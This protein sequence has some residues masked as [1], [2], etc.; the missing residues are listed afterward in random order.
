MG[1]YVC[2]TQFERLIINPELTTFRCILILDFS[3]LASFS[4]AISNIG[5]SKQIP[6]FNFVV[7][8]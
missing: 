5:I 3:V 1:I 4:L 2:L 6:K 7:N 8:T